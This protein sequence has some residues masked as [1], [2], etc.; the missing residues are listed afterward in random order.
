M[1]F[2]T[3]GTDVGTVA[4]PVS[5]LTSG[6]ELVIHITNEIMKKA[7]LTCDFNILYPKIE[8][9]ILKRC[10]ETEI[11]D[12]EEERLRK[13]LSDI[14]IQDA[15]IDLLAKEIGELSI[16]SRNQ[17]I[18]TSSL[19]LSDIEPFTWRRKHLRCKK[20]VFN[21]VAVY[22]DFE[23][24]FAKFL[25]SAND[26]K[27][28]A[29]LADKFSIDYLSS[30]GAIRFYHPDF[31]AIQKEGKNEIYWIIETKGREYED[32]DKKDATMRK[33]CED[34]SSQTGKQWKYIKI[35]QGQ[36]SPHKSFKELMGSDPNG[37]LLKGG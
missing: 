28:F 34:I 26:I 37:V 20:T 33:W 18:K 19:K 35:M 12:I 23:A 30:R 32:T 8:E 21:F 7:R 29:A 13:I 24:E 36:F 25:D 2:A 27:S 5:S 14:S 6:R 11:K 17:V 16:E 4:M 1:E 3:T 31:V 9:Y 10:F 15:I 22:N